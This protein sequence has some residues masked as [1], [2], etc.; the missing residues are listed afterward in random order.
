MVKYHD[1]IKAL[2]SISDAPMYERL[3]LVLRN[4]KQMVGVF[5]IGAGVTVMENWAPFHA[6][7]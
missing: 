7:A 5:N 6:G 4:L 3:A 2:A 1:A